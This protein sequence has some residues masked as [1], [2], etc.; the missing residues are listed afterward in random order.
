VPSQPFP[1]ELPNVTT[2]ALAGTVTARVP[3]AWVRG[4]AFGPAMRGVS[5]ALTGRASNGE[6]YTPLSNVGSGLIAPASGLRPTPPGADQSVHLPWTW[7]LDLR[8]A[9]AVTTGR[10]RWTVYLEARNLLDAHNLVAAFT[11]TGTD[12]NATFRAGQ[13]LLQVSALQSDAG[14]RWSSR[15]VV[16][17]GATLT[18]TGVDLSDCSLFP[19][20]TDGSRGV[21]D[22]LA[23]R[24]VEARWGNG[25]R[26]YDTN[27]ITRALTAWYDAAYG[28]W[29]FHGPA[30]TARVGIEVEF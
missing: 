20:P 16:V 8:L 29:A 18:Q 15:Q 21:V 13:A 19:Q 6:S 10:Y 25:D 22:C 24:Q 27:E 9:K 17:N 12:Q 11:E 4:S 23:L 5:A 1:A 7:T 3:D 2:H 30:R 14:S 28:T 26:F